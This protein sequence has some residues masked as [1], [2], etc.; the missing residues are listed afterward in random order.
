MHRILRVVIIICMVCCITYV[1]RLLKVV[2]MSLTCRGNLNTI[3]V[4]VKIHLKLK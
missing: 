2:I 1:Q 3:Y 4:S